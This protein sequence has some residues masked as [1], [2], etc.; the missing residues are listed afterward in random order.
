MWQDYFAEPPHHKNLAERANN[1]L[2]LTAP[3]VHAFC[4]AASVEDPSEKACPSARSLT[5]ALAGRA[6][7]ESEGHGGKQHKAEYADQ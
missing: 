2:K 1:A 5:L 3:S 4:I 6:V 7:D